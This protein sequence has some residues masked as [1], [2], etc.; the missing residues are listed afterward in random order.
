LLCSTSHSHRIIIARIHTFIAVRTLFTLHSL[1]PSPH[2][3]QFRT[4]N[5]MST[6]ITAAS[7]DSEQL[8]IS[9]ATSSTI[10]DATYMINS[11]SGLLEGDLYDDEL[12]GTYLSS[13]AMD[14]VFWVI[15]KDVF[16]F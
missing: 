11:F 1:A 2:I 16:K 4:K 10:D 5:T 13:A 8:K 12:N 3:H 9:T 15:E 14:R 7:V 6:T